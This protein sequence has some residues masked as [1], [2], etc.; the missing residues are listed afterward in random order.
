MT[1]RLYEGTNRQRTAFAGIL[2]ALWLASCGRPDPTAVVTCALPPDD[3]ISVH[4]GLWDSGEPTIG[5]VNTWQFL[6]GTLLEFHPADPGQSRGRGRAVHV[7]RTTT[8]DFLPSQPED[9]S[10]DIASASLRVQLDPNAAQTLGSLQQDF[11]RQIA[12][13]SYVINW[14]ATRKT[15]R[16]PVGLVNADDLAIDLLRKADQATRFSIVSA[17]SYDTSVV[18]YHSWAGVPVNIVQVRQ[19]QLHFEFMCSS[20]DRIN[21]VASLARKPVPILFVNTAVKYDPMHA[22]VIVD[23]LQLD[24][25][26]FELIDDAP[27]GHVPGPGIPSSTNPVAVQKLGNHALDREGE[28]NK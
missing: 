17:V 2:L 3:M 18:L 15:L 14:N 7:L 20:L 9:W 4:L 25:T 28:R 12:I 10:E 23:P 6:P 5:I 26:A 11:A 24:L 1:R 13:S 21:A 19:F 22:K 8:E 27:N 16:D